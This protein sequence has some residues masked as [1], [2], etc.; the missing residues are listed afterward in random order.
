MLTKLFLHFGRW[1]GV[2]GLPCMTSAKCLGFFYPNPLCLYFM[3]CLSAK[4]G[5]FLTPLPPSVRTSYMEAHLRRCSRE[6]RGGR[7]R[8]SAFRNVKAITRDFAFPTSL[9]PSLCV[10]ASLRLR[11]LWSLCSQSKQAQRNQTDVGNFVYNP[12]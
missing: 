3:Y 10:C 12:A 6:S 11:R 2:R 4:L 5:Y 7:R 9:P 8:R 1:M